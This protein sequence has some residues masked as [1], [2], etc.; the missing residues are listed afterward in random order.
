VKAVM[1]D[2]LQLTRLPFCSAED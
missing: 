1:A 2:T